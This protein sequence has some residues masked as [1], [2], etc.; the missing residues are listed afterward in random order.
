MDTGMMQPLAY[1][2]CSPDSAGNHALNCPM[3]AATRIIINPIVVPGGPF[4]PPLQPPI[5]VPAASPLFPQPLNGWLCP[6]C[7]GGNSPLS[8]RCPCTP[9]MPGQGNTVTQVSTQVR[10]LME[11]S[12]S[13]D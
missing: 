13:T 1:C 3:Y 6:V 12:C 9:A 10:S 2:T 7:G 8:M 11:L 4:Q 5:Q